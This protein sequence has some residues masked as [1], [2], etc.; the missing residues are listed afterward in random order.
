MTANDDKSYFRYFNK[1]VDQYN[2]AYHPSLNKKPINADYSVL[3]EK[4][5]INP[6]V[7]KFKVNDIIRITEYKNISENISIKIQENWL[8]EM[9][10]IDY[11]VFFIFGHIQIK[12]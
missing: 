8:R 12:I 10:I 4:N 6:K 3:I 9:F 1:L 11:Y 5:E 2:N 7:R